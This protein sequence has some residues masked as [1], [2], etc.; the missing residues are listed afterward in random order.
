[1]RFASLAIAVGFLL[2]KLICQWDKEEVGTLLRW[3]GT[4]SFANRPARQAYSHSASV[5]KRY[6]CF[7]PVSLVQSFAK[8]SAS[9]QFTFSTGRSDLLKWL[10]NR[11]VPLLIETG[12]QNRGHYCWAG[13]K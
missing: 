11:Q 2:L 5:G 8:L 7:P 12:H 3:K 6:L 4:L 1:V 13:Q 10:G 9:V